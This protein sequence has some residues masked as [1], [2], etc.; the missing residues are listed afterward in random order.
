MQS[1]VDVV[2]DVLIRLKELKNNSK[3]GELCYIL[4]ERSCFLLVFNLHR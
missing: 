3:D 4:R 1:V 2:V